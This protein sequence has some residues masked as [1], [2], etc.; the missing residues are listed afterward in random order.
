MVPTNR[1]RSHGGDLGQDRHGDAA[2]RLHNPVRPG[3]RDHPGSAFRLSTGHRRQQEFDA[4]LRIRLSP[5]HVPPPPAVDRRWWRSPR[6]RGRTSIYATDDDIE[7][8][9]TF[10]QVVAVDVI[11]GTPRIN[12][13]AGRAAVPVAGRWAEYASGSGSDGAGVRLPG[14]GHGRIRHG[15]HRGWGTFLHSTTDHVDLNGGTIT[16]VAT[17]EDASLAY[18]PVVSD[19]GHRVNW[20]RPALSGA[21][22][23]TDGT[24][25]ILTFSEDLDSGTAVGHDLVHGQGG[26]HGRDAE[27]N[28]GYGLRQQ[29]DAAAGH[30]AHLGDAGGDGELHRSHQRGRLHRPPGP[31]GQRRRLLHRPDGDQPLHGADGA[32]HRGPLLGGCPRD[33]HPRQCLRR[34]EWWQWFH[35][36]RVPE[37]HRQR[38]D[39]ESRRDRRLARHH[40][41]FKRPQSSGG[42]DARHGLHLRGTGEERRRPRARRPEHR[43]HGGRDV[44]HRGGA[45]LQPRDGHDLRHRRGRRGDAH[46][47][48]AGDVRGGRGEP[49]AA[50]ARFRRDGQAGHVR[51]H[52]PADRRGVHLHGGER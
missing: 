22:T 39:L 9:A 35:Q 46:V 16:V 10:D 43:N 21:V 24:K 12:A 18:T 11:G 20:V 14:G 27:R 3:S 51:R 5:T 7:V 41:R 26:R 38:D 37:Q 48:P 13:P 25:V 28:G 17:G 32:E 23:S 19:S 50:R 33:D 34:M 52:E 4:I 45:H 30:S 49:A 8:T 1:R 36:S 31:G 40:A 6:I 15:R 2:S 29:R 47:Q 44:H 42:P